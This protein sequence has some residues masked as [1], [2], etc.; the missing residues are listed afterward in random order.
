MRTDW[1]SKEAAL[2]PAPAEP[3]PADMPQRPLGD[4]LKERETQPPAIP[5]PTGKPEPAEPMSSK[6]LGNV[7]ETSAKALFDA[8]LTLEKA[9]VALLKVRP[10]SSPSALDKEVAGKAQGFAEAIKKMGDSIE[11]LAKEVSA[12]REELAKPSSPWLE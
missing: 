6:E 12:Y 9:H 4:I 11:A 3:A 10:M 7:M 2:P 5:N 1:I 8:K